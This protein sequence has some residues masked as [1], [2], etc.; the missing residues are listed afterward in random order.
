MPKRGPFGY[1]TRHRGSHRVNIPGPT[2]RALGL[3]KGDKP[4]VGVPNCRVCGQ[5]MRPM[6]PRT[7]LGEAKNQRW[8]CRQD[9]QLY[10]AKLNR[11][12]ELTG[13]QRRRHRI[14]ELLARV[15]F[16]IL[17]PGLFMAGVDYFQMLSGG[18]PVFGVW[19][20]L[21]FI[22]IGG[23]VGICGRIITRKTN[24]LFG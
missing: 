2:L 17:A 22:L 10:Y 24:P 19:T 4:S 3:K 8:Y 6:I 14:G 13:A 5:P 7:I 21:P 20:E 16:V 9:G 15:G 18:Y 23:I 12:E 11:W 1:L